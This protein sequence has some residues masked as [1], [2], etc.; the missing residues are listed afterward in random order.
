MAFSCVTIN[1]NGLIQRKIHR[2]FFSWL[3]KKKFYIFS[4]RE[5]HGTVNDVKKCG[6]GNI[7]VKALVYG[8]TG[9]GHSV[10]LP[11]F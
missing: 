10:E 3:L 11:P 1:I 7:W 2:T 4:L 8:T 6:G 9:R 5:T